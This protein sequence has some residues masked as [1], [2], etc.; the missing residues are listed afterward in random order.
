MQSIPSLK[1]LSLGLA[2]I[3]FL[4]AGVASAQSLVGVNARLDHTLDTKHATVGEVVTAKLDGSV[5]AAD[6]I[7]LP[8][9]TE[10][11]GKVD[12]VKNAEKGPV[13]VSL[14]FTTAKLKDGKQIPVKVT[15]LSAYPESI[16][17]GPV[18]SADSLQAAPAQVSSDR[19]FDQEPGALRNVA[20]KS[21]VKDS[22]SGTFS[23]SNGNFRLTAGTYFQFGVA[24]AGNSTATSAV[25]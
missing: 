6:G 17:D 7:T 2:V 12:E 15:L 14:V 21:A 1:N 13:S 9:G 22:D 25:E 20:M 18:D 8:K 24:P 11:I 4:S 3:S 19:T 16:G 23:S 5:K 10:L